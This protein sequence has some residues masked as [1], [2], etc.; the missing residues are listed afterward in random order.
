MND[1]FIQAFEYT[2]KNEGTSFTN[3]LSDSGGPTK[4]GI[5]QSA[6]DRWIGKDLDQV[7]SV[8]FMSVGTAKQIYFDEYWRPMN[9]HKLLYPGTAICL[10]DSGVLYGIGTASKIAQKVA[11]Y[12][13]S[14]IKRDGFI[15]DKSIEAINKI[16]QSDFVRQFHRIVLDRIDSII[17]AYPKNEEYRRGWT[18]RADRLLTLCNIEPVMK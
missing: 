15:G 1:Y 14:S 13:G 4:F 6:F 8:E 16:S 5:T 11:N 7:A 10:F 18:S 12:Y 2:L 3:Y 9:C 17:L